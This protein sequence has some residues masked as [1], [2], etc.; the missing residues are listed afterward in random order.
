MQ[1]ALNE[2]GERVHI[3]DAIRHG[4][5]KC[6]TCGSRVEVRKGTKKIPYFAHWR[7]TLRDNCENWHHDKSDWHKSWQNLFPIDCQEVSMTNEE[8]IR[9]IADV[10]T[11]DKIVEFQHSPMSIEEFNKRNEFYTSLGKTVIWLFDV[12][13]AARDERLDNHILLK[14][15][16]Q[17]INGYD[18]DNDN[19]M[20]FIQVSG[21]NIASEEDATSEIRRIVGKDEMGFKTDLS[22]SSGDFV[23]FVKGDVSYKEL[24]QNKEHEEKLSRCRTLRRIMG[25]SLNPEIIAINVNTGVEAKVENNEYIFNSKQITGRI[26]KP[27]WNTFTKKIYP[28]DGQNEPVWMMC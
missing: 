16:I 26:R 14:K 3:N 15:E 20:V 17:A 9:H 11:D 28:I 27:G 2:N 7:N 21:N 10:F 6:Q 23:S 13:S 18:P 19:I 12:R 24:I 22:I 8:G 4:N 25:Q 1:I 5:Y